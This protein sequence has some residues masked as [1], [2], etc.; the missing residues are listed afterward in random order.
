MPPAPPSIREL[1]ARLGVSRT[2]VSLALRRHP[3]VAPET[4]ARILAEAKKS[5][6][7]SN[8]LVNALMSQVRN[9]KRIKPTGEVLAYLTSH[10]S[11]DDWKRHPSHVQQF[12]GAQ[13]RAEELGF[14]LQPFWLGDRGVGSRQLARVLFARG[15]RG[16]LLAPIHIDHHTLELDWDGHAIVTIGYSFRQVALHR[17][18]H[19]NISLVTACHDQIRKLGHSRIGLAL[20]RTDNSRVRHLWATGF[21]GQRQFDGEHIE[22]LLFDSFEDAGPF[23]RWLDHTRPQAVISIWQDLP[24]TWMREAGIKVPKEIS[25]ATLDLGDRVGK[26]AGMLQDNHGIGSAAMDLLAGQ[27]FRNEIGI[28]AT[29]KITMI[30]G[31]WMDG[32]TVARRDT[33]PRRRRITLRETASD[34]PPATRPPPAET[35][36]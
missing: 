11:E 12:E 8:A 20:H 9:R 13:K 32:P 26:I 29:P 28:P 16:S 21:L 30:E 27:L 18:V 31:T 25:Y 33:S 23:L 24:L 19:D 5:G 17:A 15:V 7:H 14:R 1:A 2:T 35:P 3:S 36:R 4:S 6:Y 34:T 22:P 10:A